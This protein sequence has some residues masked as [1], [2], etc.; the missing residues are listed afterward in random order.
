MSIYFQFTSEGKVFWYRPLS[1]CCRSWKNAYRSC[2]VQNS[3]WTDPCQ[4]PNTSFYRGKRKYPLNQIGQDPETIKTNLHLQPEGIYISSSALHWC[5]FWDFDPNNNQ[6]VIS[7]SL[8]YFREIQNLSKKC[9][10]LQTKTN[11]IYY[12]EKFEESVSFSG[13][14]ESDQYLFYRIKRHFN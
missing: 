11:K 4:T 3:R 9:K 7:N 6:R 13:I 1:T 5:V 8:R 10:F 14:H 2:P 12:Y